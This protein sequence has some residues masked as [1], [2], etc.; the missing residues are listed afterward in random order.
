MS[1]FVENLNFFKIMKRYLIIKKIQSHSQS[2]GKGSLFGVELLSAFLITVC[3]ILGYLFLKTELPWYW[4]LPGI[5]VI[6]FYLIWVT[7]YVRKYNISYSGIQKLILK[8]EEGRNIK[9]WYVEDKK[10]LLIG[11][12]AQDNEVDIDLSESEYVTLISKQHAVLNF[13]DNIWY[14]ED[15]GSSNG[16]GLKKIN[17]GKK[18]KL[19]QGILYK[20]NSGDT[21][22]I[23]NTKLVVK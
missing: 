19:E 22:Y 6:L 5:L 2:K 21:I 4:F 11:R 13:S 8:D 17:E 20:I 1:K 18:F 15:I 9:E 3:L 7:I 16:T 14:I 10:S 23:A 12:K